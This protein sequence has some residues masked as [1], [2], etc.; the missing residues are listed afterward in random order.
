L[1]AKD[2]NQAEYYFKRG[3][4]EAQLMMIENSTKDYLKAASKGYREASAYFNVG[5]N[6]MIES[7]TLSIKYFKKCLEKDSS[8]PKVRE[9]LQEA[10]ETLGSSK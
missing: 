1:I 5:L 6:Y 3:Y 10:L 9:K 8:H 2:S 4:C 7:D